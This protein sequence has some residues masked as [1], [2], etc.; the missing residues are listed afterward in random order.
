MPS[1]P[2]S[3]SRERLWVPA[4]V[5]PRRLVTAPGP[6]S[7]HCQFS[8]L[9]SFLVLSLCLCQSQQD[10]QEESVRRNSRISAPGWVGRNLVC[11]HG[12]TGGVVCSSEAPL[13]VPCT[14]EE[15]SQ[16]RVGR[17]R[18]P[19]P[20]CLQGLVHMVQTAVCLFTLEAAQWVSFPKP[21]AKPL[22]R[23]A[24]LLLFVSLLE[25]KALLAPAVPR[26]RSQEAPVWQSPW[27]RV[28]AGFLLEKDREPGHRELLPWGQPEMSLLKHLSAIRVLNAHQVCLNVTVSL[29]YPDSSCCI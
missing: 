5:T 18:R 20:V 14:A 24:Q 17:W 9:P 2:H 12:L 29:P 1:I 16:R 23:R 25:R 3:K 6:S 7:R 19:A 4:G 28:R 27:F 22:S 15:V 8:L 26:A 13:P 21:R 11:S 10:Q